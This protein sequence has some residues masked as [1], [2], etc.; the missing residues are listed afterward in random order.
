M[1]LEQIFPNYT[2]GFDGL[3]P[4]PVRGAKSVPVP[5]LLQTELTGLLE[6]CKLQVRAA[7]TLCFGLTSCS[8][9]LLMQAKIGYTQSAHSSKVPERPFFNIVT[10]LEK[11]RFLRF[12]CH[13]FQ[14]TLSE[15]DRKSVV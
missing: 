1:R 14:L 5:L 2:P 3:K 7:H 6:L 8:E 10:L 4:V 12:V 15:Q 9:G 13:L 11:V